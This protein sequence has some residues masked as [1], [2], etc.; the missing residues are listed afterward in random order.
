GQH[1]ELGIEP[2]H[3]IAQFSNAMCPDEIRDRFRQQSDRKGNDDERKGRDKEY[4]PPSM[5][6]YHRIAK[7]GRQH[8]ADR[9][10]TERHGHHRRAMLSRSKLRYVCHDTRHDATDPYAGHETDHTEQH[11]IVDEAGA[12]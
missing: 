6:L 11:G 9:K 7:D 8:S 12:D 5:R 3:D 10:A 2:A 4:R 1:Y